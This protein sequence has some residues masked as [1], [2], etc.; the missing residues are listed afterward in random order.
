VEGNEIYGCAYTPTGTTSCGILLYN[1]A[2]IAGTIQV[3]DNLIDECETGAYYINVAGNADGNTITATAAG[4]GLS[5]YYG[6]IIDPGT[7]RRVKPVPSEETMVAGSAGNMAAGV[8]TLSSS[9]TGNTI[10]GDGSGVGLEVDAYSVANGGDGTLNFTGTSNVVTGFANGVVL[11]EDVDATLTSVLSLNKIQYNGLG[12]Y[13]EN[14]SVD[15]Q[16]NSICYNTVSADDNTA[17]NFYDQNSWS[18]WN[19]VA[20]YN[21]GGAGANVDNNPAAGCG[22]DM[23]PHEIAYDCDG[24]FSFD[25]TIGADVMGVGI[26][27]II[28]DYP[29]S[30]T[31]TS[32]TAVDPM[33]LIGFSQTNN[34]PGGTDV[35]NVA[36]YD[37]EG[38]T[39]DGP[40]TLFTVTMSGSESCLDAMINMRASSKLWEP[41]YIPI[42]TSLSAPIHL[43]TDCADPIFTLNG[44]APG[45]CYGPAPVLDIS[46]TDDCE[47]DA[48]YYQIDGCAGT[49]LPVAT[50]LV[51]TAYNNAAWEIPGYAGLSDGVHC[52]YFKVVDD[53]G[54]ES[55]DPCGFSWCFTKDLTGP[56]IT[57]PADFSVNCVD[58]IAPCDP[59]DATAV[60]ACGGVVTITC[61]D[62]PYSGDG[63]V[64]EVVRTFVA[65]DQ[66]GNTSSCDQV[67]TVEDVTP[68]TIAC[69][70]DIT[71]QR[72][73]DLPPCNTE[74]VTV[75]DNCGGT[76]FVTCERSNV[77][78]VGCT[79]DPVL[80]TYTWTA[81]DECGNEAQCSR[82]ITVVRPDCPF[83]V[84]AGNSSEDIS[85]FSGQQLTLPINAD[86][87]STEI[88]AFDLAVRY[89]KNAVTVLGVDR[90]AAVSAWEYFTYR[91]ENST[92]GSGVIRLVGIADLNDGVLPPLEAFMPVGVLAN[93]RMS[94]TSDPAYVGRS[95]SLDPCLNG[96]TDNTVVTRDG[97]KTIAMEEANFDECASS[98]SGMVVPGVKFASARLEVTEPTSTVGDINLNGMGYEVGDVVVLANYLVNGTP[99]LSPD[100]TLRDL[101]IAASDAN[102]DGVVLTVAD[103]R[104]LLRVVSGSA[105]PAI[106]K[107]SPYA[108]IGQTHYSVD[109]GR[110]VVSTDANVELGGAHFI[111][112]YNNLSVGSPTLSDAASQMTIRAN[113]ESGELRILVSTTAD[114]M[115][116]VNAGRRELF[117]APVTGDG[118]LEMV[119]VQM[120]DANGALL[121][122]SAYKSVVPTDYA[123]EQNY[124]NPFNAGTVIPFALKDASEWTVTIYNVIGQTVRTFAGRNDAGRVMVAWDG[125]DEAGTAVSS[126]V[127]FYR[128]ETANWHATKK[129]TLVK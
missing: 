105:T 116:S 109:N 115:A 123:L 120:S 21:V 17:G 20:P 89:D 34:A 92:D 54:R 43:I 104:F 119:E 126:G 80:V 46:A 68:P 37:A 77:G 9:A 127:Y 55:A 16:N 33:D 22:L 79:D 124:P 90:G 75:S 24:E 28:M 98:L 64:G 112:R 95:F 19:G 110:L 40:A 107:L 11:W 58:E 53:F 31:V 63:C 84:S 81:V 85:A 74:D 117:T 71:V 39:L 97:G 62:A 82:V 56:D 44:P 7:E 87:M 122:S 111:F 101:Q 125:N 78:G 29:S 2:P 26:A 94:V 49:W 23:T 83:A 41:G 1:A 32:V 88:G 3:K 59:N 65:T 60:D 113:A 61:S 121:L 108:N 96:C 36:V 70:P 91:L 45:A 73:L 13:N 67:I 4:T 66:F 129:M 51:G 30:L 14:G 38:G 86:E 48:V 57:C 93:V 69:L 76:V 47:L 114:Q 50:G 35:L 52:V 18:D 118:S 10:T 99:A 8:S 100:Q 106:G 5:D 128:V 6:L 42:P 72:F 102:G 12:L 25:V 15:A 103:L 27:N